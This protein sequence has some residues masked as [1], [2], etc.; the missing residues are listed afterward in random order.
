MWFARDFFFRYEMTV[1]AEAK[2]KEPVESVEFH[3]YVQF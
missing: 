2:Q 1:D 3:I